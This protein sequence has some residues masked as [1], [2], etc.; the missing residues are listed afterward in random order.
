MYKGSFYTA[1]S[2]NNFGMSATLVYQ[3]KCGQ[4]IMHAIWLM[5]R[6]VESPNKPTPW[7][8]LQPPEIPSNRFP[9]LMS[10][11]PGGQ[12]LHFVLLQQNGIMPWAP[13]QSYVNARFANGQTWA[14]MAHNG[15]CYSVIAGVTDDVTGKVSI[16]AP[17]NTV[18]GSDEVQDGMTWRCLGPGPGASR[19]DPKTWIW[20]A[21]GDAA[22]QL[23]LNAYAETNWPWPDGGQGNSEKINTQWGWYTLRTPQLFDVY[24]AGDSGLIDQAGITS[25]PQTEWTR[26]ENGVVVSQP[27]KILLWKDFT[28]AVPGLSNNYR[29]ALPPSRLLNQW[30]DVL[31]SR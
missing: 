21:V 6:G 28:G 20:I 31:R 12:W 26:M 1:D 30:F 23:V 17:T 14:Q 15:F 5:S 4:P 8:Q 29:S 9:T 19:L 3:N 2:P 7:L 22:P 13:G 24:G 10:S 27:E 16:T 18:T 25:Y 11:V